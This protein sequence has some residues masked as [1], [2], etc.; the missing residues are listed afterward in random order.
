MAIKGRLREASLPD[1]L[2]LLA[3][4]KKT[5]CL[6]VTNKQQF[7]TIHFE[8][9]RISHAAIVNRRDRL[10]DLLVK[11]G[12]IGPADL[13][14]AQQRLRESGGALTTHIITTCGVSEAE[15][16][17]V[18]QEEYR[19]PVVDPAA[20]DIPPEVIDV[21]KHRKATDNLSETD[22]AIIEL[23]REIWV[24]HKVSSATF[25]RAKALFAPQD[26]VDLVMLMGMYAQTAALLIAF[27]MQLRPGQQPLL[28]VE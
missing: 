27:D 20:L 17:A 26:L 3:M 24:D 9:G 19:L 25:A 18:L 21:I 15:L 23:G 22:A 28:P 14:G 1:V 7:G 5:G 11:H 6:S 16:L 4:G 12:L 8:K 10:G 2:Q 13:R